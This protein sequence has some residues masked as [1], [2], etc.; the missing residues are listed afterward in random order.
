VSVAPLH[1]YT[2][3]SGVGYG[4]HL[5]AAQGLKI[6]GHWNLEQSAKTVCKWLQRIVSCFAGAETA[7][8]SFN[9]HESESIF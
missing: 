4:G 7:S 6:H 9:T 8:A 2:D 5:A 1:V 3:A